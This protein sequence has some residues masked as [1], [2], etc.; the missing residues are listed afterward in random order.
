M[1]EIKRLEEIVFPTAV[2]LG[3]DLHYGQELR[4]LN[5]AYLHLSRVYDKLKRLGNL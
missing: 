4:P 5:T 1:A 2:S 3:Y